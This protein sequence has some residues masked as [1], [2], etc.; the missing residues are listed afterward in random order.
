MIELRPVTRTDAQ[1]AVRNWHS[2]HKPHLGELWA[3][4]AFV[5]GEM[6]GVVVVGRPVA[7]VLQ[8][9]GCLEV[10]RLAVNGY[11]NA[12]SRLLGA[13]WG[14][15]K[16]M[17]CR[18]LISYTR[19]DEEGTCYHAAGWRQTATV[20]GR[21]WTSGNKSDRWLPGF[22]QP[23]TEIIDRVRWEIGPDALPALNN[24]GRRLE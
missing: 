23:T 24:P 22:Y 21:G 9:Q 5:D 12:A 19:I 17:G 11:R 7:P 16:A 15:A 2:H 18:R 14:A 13:A 6:V 4:G 1:A 10:T 20:K 8:A 3:V